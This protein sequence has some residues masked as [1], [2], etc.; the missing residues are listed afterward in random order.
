MTTRDVCDVLIEDHR[1]LQQL[2]G[3]LREGAV[4][5]DHAREAADR[6]IAALVRHSVAEEM[7][8]YPVVREYLPDGADAVEHDVTEHQQLEELLVQ[9][10]D[11]DPLDARFLEVV[12]SIQATLADHIQDE[13][14]EQ[15]PQLRAHVPSETLVR[16]VDKVEKAE[17]IAPTRPHPAAPHSELFHEAVGPGVGMVDRLRDAL[18]GRL[19]A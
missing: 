17:R 18:S 12:G 7:Y 10:E 9:L 5:G 8:V 3:E 16:L 13:E 1:R 14:A 15:F 6:F 19:T 2:L 11:V 4:V